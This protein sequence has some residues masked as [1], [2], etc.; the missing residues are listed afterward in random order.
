MED[1]RSKE[2]EVGVE[3]YEEIVGDLDYSTPVTSRSASPNRYEEDRSTVA[4]FQGPIT[5]S[6]GGAENAGLENAGVAKMQGWKTRDW[7]MQK[8]EKYGKRRFQKCVSD[9]TD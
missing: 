5:H 9:C 6:S 8:S 4:T 1:S 2:T 7:K 3:L